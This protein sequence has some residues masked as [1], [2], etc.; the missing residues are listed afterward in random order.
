MHTK[1]LNSSVQFYEVVV[2]TLMEMFAKLMKSSSGPPGIPCQ[3]PYNKHLTKRQSANHRSVA[4]FGSSGS[5]TLT[6]CKCRPHA[7]AFFQFRRRS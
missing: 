3:R 1:S 6:S 2:V 5:T 4:C 7:F